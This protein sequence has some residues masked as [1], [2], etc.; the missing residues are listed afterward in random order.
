M[1][2]NFVENT[3][4]CL[5]G[6]PFWCLGKRLQNKIKD[7]IMIS[8][9]ELSWSQ[10]Y[11]TKHTYLAQGVPWSRWRSPLT[12][13]LPLH[14]GLVDAGDHLKCRWLGCVIFVS[15]G[16]RSRYP[17]IYIKNGT[18]KHADWPGVQ[19]IVQVFFLFLINIGTFWFF[20]L[21]I[22]CLL[23]CWWRHVFKMNIG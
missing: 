6:Q 18:C 17:L 10:C 2:S 15:G 23:H 13:T 21:H 9:S 5:N 8:T 7:T 12:E 22:A 4:G 16:L 14:F 1:L 11:C 19:V 20:G 3:N